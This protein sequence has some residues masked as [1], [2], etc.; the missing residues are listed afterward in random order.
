MFTRP[1]F[2]AGVLV[3]V[4]FLA[5]C[6]A[7]PNELL[8]SA[9]SEGIVAGFWHGLW[10]GFISLFAFIASVFW[11]DVAIYEV[12][13]NGA[14]YDLGFVLGVMSFFGGGGGGARRRS[15]K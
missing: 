9:G 11:D 12:H 8:G 3:A 1:L 6:A 15:K 7:G 13:N 4:M 14:W 2:K 5:A 10:H